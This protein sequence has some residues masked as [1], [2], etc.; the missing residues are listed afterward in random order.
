M[1]NQIAGLA[2]VVAGATIVLM[3]IARGRDLS[4]DERNAVVTAVFGLFLCGRYIEHV[5]GVLDWVTAIATAAMMILLA[6]RNLG[7]DKA[8]G[9]QTHH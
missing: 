6:H 2:L 1:F 9:N 4:G 3:L 5:G 7:F 8:A